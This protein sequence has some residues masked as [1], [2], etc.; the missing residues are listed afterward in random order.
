MKTAD[1]KTLEELAKEI[2]PLA[3]DESAVVK[4]M[5]GQARRT[6]PLIPS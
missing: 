2:Q 1:G 3:A 5:A 4:A 6:A